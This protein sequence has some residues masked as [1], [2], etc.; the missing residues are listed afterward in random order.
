MYLSLGGHARRQPPDDVRRIILLAAIPVLLAIL[1]AGVAS[2][3]IPS[4]IVRVSAEDA[5]RSGSAIGLVPHAVGGSRLLEIQPGDGAAHLLAVSPDGAQVALA[6]RVGELFGSLIIANADGSQLRVSLPGL[7][8]AG[9]AADG[10]WLAAVDGRGV[11]WRVD[12]A[13][14]EVR[15]LAE[16]PFLGTPIAVADGSLMLLSVPSVEAAYQSRLIRIVPSSGAVT[17]LASDELVYA[18]YPLDDGTLAV[19]AHKR[20]G[21]VVRRVGRGVSRLL[22][23]LG[24]GAI[25]VAVTKDGQGIAFEKAGRGI[26]L[27]DRPGAAP[28]SLGPGAKPCFAADGSMLLV[29]RGDAAAALSVDGS[30]LAVTDRLTGIVGSVGCLP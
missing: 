26:F 9:Y 23:D 5:A 28:R 10:S 16:G 4:G 24:P 12:P 19:V 8:S 7:L 27:V 21:T 25:N 6:D 1:A 30:V 2:A 15:Q 29:Q 11:L 14:G 13:A 20:G 17:T 3:D 22:A 18:G